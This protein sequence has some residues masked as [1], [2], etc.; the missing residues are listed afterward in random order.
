MKVYAVV[1]VRTDPY[2]AVIADGATLGLYTS[3]AAA[4]AQMKVLKEK[5]HRT[6]KLAVRT[7]TVRD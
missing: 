7:M 3:R 5:L 6:V 1:T 4:T 2:G